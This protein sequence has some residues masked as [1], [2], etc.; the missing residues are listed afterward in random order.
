VITQR[1]KEAFYDRVDNNSLEL[2]QPSLVPIYVELKGPRRP[3]DQVGTGF[4]I[5]HQDRTVLVTA[6]HV[7]RGR[8]SN[9]DPWEKVVIAAGHRLL[10]GDLN[11]NSLVEAIDEDAAILFVDEF[12]AERCL[13]SSVLSEAHSARILTLHGFLGRDFNRDAVA[14]AAFPAPW[15]I[16]G[17]IGNSS[18]RWLEMKYPRSRFRDPQTGLVVTAPI[19]AGIS[20]GPMLDSL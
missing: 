8:E 9:E 18:E 16:T 14:D 20:G 13:P 4:L 19:P 1:Q 11:R 15:V 7:L 5:R 12:G 6:K 10:L 3:L 17:A 2:V